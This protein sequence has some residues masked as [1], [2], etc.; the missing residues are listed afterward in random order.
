ME[1]SYVYWPHRRPCTTDER[2]LAAA[3]SENEDMLL[4]IFEEGNFDINT[5]DGCVANHLCT[6]ALIDLR[7]AVQ[8]REYWYATILEDS[9][10]AVSLI[11]LERDPQPCI[12]R[13]YVGYTCDLPRSPDLMRIHAKFSAM[14][15]YLDILEHLLEYEGCDVDLQNRTEGA[16]PLHLALRIEDDDLRKAVVES[17]L[18]AGADYKC[19]FRSG[20]LF[21]RAAGRRT[22]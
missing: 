5:K 4:E 7:F 18:D 6:S 21:R 11:V 13:T 15:G 14:N 3:R 12:T 10:A 8:T 22:G 20:L 1:V 19:V 9:P 2:L 16:T 17:L